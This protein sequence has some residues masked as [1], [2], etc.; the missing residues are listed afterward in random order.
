M[1][2]DMA[3]A[4]RLKFSRRRIDDILILDLVGDLMSGPSSNLLRQE[5]ANLLD[6][7]TSK[8]IL[9]LDCLR[10]ID[11]T[12]IGAL[13]ASK[14]SAVNR[15]AQL[16]FCCLPPAVARL[17]GQLRLT[18][19]LKIYDEEQSAIRSYRG[20]PAAESAADNCGS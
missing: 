19:V 10:Y 13:L 3:T 16:R 20:Q 6:G 4:T 14:T 12:G 17:L 7:G 5:V 1:R 8:I 2:S 11:S 18:K 15:H 9:N